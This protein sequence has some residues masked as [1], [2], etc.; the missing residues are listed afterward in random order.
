MGNGE[1]RG[2]TLSR[3][4]GYM[5][6]FNIQYSVRSIQRYGVLYCMMSLKWPHRLILDP[7]YRGPLSGRS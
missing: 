3:I 4:K 6:I 5:G 1:R 2:M 7:A